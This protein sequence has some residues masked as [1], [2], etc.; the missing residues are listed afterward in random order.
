MLPS[1]G[2]TR[3]LRSIGHQNI[4]PI[5]WWFPASFPV[6]LYNLYY[7][8]FHFLFHYPYIIPHIGALREP[9][10]EVYMRRHVSAFPPSVTESTEV[11]AGMVA[12]KLCPFRSG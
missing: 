1:A 4:T 10:G 6:S 12:L 5:L 11:S 3:Q 9:I 8:G 2:S 7:G